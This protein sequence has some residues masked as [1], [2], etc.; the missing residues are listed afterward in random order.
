MRVG[1][2]ACELPMLWG[3]MSLSK[4]PESRSL[5]KPTGPAQLGGKLAGMS[6]PKQVFVLSLWPFLGQVLN[7][8][9]G[10][11]DTAL[12][13]RLSVEA[14][15]AIGVAAYFGWLF[16]IVFMAVGNGS[17]ALIARAIGAR[18]KRLANA[19]LGQSML[20]A[21]GAGV[22]MG[23]LIFVTTPWLV[24]LIGL[25][26]ESYE[27]CVEFLRIFSLAAPCAAVL[28][29]GGACLRGAGDAKTPFMVL[30]LVNIVNIVVSVLL[31]QGPEPIGGHGVHGIA[32]GTLIAWVVGCVVTLVV[33]VRGVGGA[34][35]LRAVRLLPRWET[36][37]RIVNVG[38][39]SLLEGF[40]GMWLA[41]A[42]ILKMLGWL[43]NDS[44][45]AAHVVTL[46]IEG[47][48]Y[49][50]AYAIGAA[51]ATLAGQYLGAGD[52][53]QARRA[54]NLCWLGGAAISFVM[55]LVFIFLPEMLVRLY[56]DQ[57]ELLAESPRLLFIC[58]FIQVFFA[59]AIVL[60][61]GMR[62]AGDT[63]TMLWLTALS[64]YG[65]RLPLVYV[66]GVYMELGLFGVWLGLCIEL[67]F[68]GM[69]FATRYLIGG[70]EKVEV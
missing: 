69:L 14:T 50:T 30:L 5:I 24:A 6:L 10:S 23:I 13:G 21:A 46:R 55:G 45:W 7:F 65:V 54:M 35:R 67:A 31:V 51:A 3:S 48:S 28:F 52:P 59:S 42:L 56:T 20:L 2:L 12:A 26:G 19:A 18:H 1:A 25:E 57:P 70:W 61:Q 62:G 60:G 39:P 33:L 8:L 32:I 17:T 53:A 29:V 27:L 15:N 38:Y 41:N 40:L 22:A 16:G 4:Q 64:T 47:V 34:I 37:K 49:L 11:V 36:A 68:R 63:R 43:N 9:V 66:L 44:A 58:G